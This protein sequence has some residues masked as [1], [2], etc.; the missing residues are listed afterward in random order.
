M[1]R[2]ALEEKGG[3][4]PQLYLVYVDEPSCQSGMKTA[5]GKR[6]TPNFIAYT[7]GR[8]VQ[9]NSNCIKVVF[10]DTR[11]M[12]NDGGAAFNEKVLLWNNLG[13]RE[14]ICPRPGDQRKETIDQNLAAQVT[15]DIEIFSQRYTVHLILVVSDVDY[16]P[17]IVTQLERG[18]YVHVI[19]TAPSSLQAPSFAKRF[20]SLYILHQ[21]NPRAAASHYSRMLVT[22]SK[23][24]NL[25]DWLSS[26]PTHD[27]MEWLVEQHAQ[28][29]T[30]MSLIETF[31]KTPSFPWQTAELALLARRIRL[32]NPTTGISSDGIDREI[33]DILLDMGVIQHVRKQYTSSEQM[34]ALEELIEEVY[35]RTRSFSSLMHILSPEGA[36]TE[37]ALRKKVI[38][39]LA[40]HSSK[41]S[42]KEIVPTDAESWNPDMALEW[43]TSPH[44]TSRERTDAYE[45]L[46]ENHT[47]HLWRNVLL[48]VKDVHE[49]MLLFFEHLAS[50][51]DNLFTSRTISIMVTNNFLL[52]DE[53]DGQISVNATHVFFDPLA[54][55]KAV[56]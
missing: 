33:A 49:D 3:Y 14:R 42:S 38:D 19:S 22:Q 17:L 34:I 12:E 26:L 8:I 4:K 20:S 18:V 56:A 15:Q 7:I 48:E 10:I 35:L 44:I 30:R 16:A 55:S 21:V 2:Q 27:F 25:C 23:Q 53:V 29:V 39:Q 32:A 11:G 24:E 54:R 13:F 9:K 51:S 43:L 37:D 6:V 45:Q 50:G 5:A 40:P 52:F 47:I 36:I 46:Q 41:R 31:G 28:R 1:E